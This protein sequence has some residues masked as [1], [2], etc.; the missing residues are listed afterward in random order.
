MIE[1]ESSPRYHNLL[2]LAFKF[3][4]DILLRL[5]KKELIKSRKRRKPIYLLLKSLSI[6]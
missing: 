2:I 6:R 3:D 4:R 5:Q 1:L